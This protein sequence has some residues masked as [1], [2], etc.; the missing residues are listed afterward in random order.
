MSMAL[1][2]LVRTS[3]ISACA[4]TNCTSSEHAGLSEQGKPGGG[5]VSQMMGRRAE[6]SVFHLRDQPER[7]SLQ[8][9]LQQLARV[10]VGLEVQPEL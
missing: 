6:A 10:D 3:A 9:P 4:A 1:V 7:P 5:T 2:G 8:H